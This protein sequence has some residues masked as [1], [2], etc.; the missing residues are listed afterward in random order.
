MRFL[1]QPFPQGLSHAR[2][3]GR[4]GIHENMAVASSQGIPDIGGAVLENTKQTYR[5]N[6]DISTVKTAQWNSG[7]G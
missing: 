7:K 6:R 4:S 5:S 1:P 2:V 3:F